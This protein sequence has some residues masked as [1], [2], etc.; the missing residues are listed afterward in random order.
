MEVT[1]HDWTNRRHDDRVATNADQ[2][3]FSAIVHS[4][5]NIEAGTYDDRVAEALD[6]YEVVDPKSVERWAATDITLDNA[7]GEIGSEVRRRQAMLRDAYPFKIN[8]NQLIYKGSQTLVYEFCLAVSTA[9]SL[10]RADHAKLPVAFE[11]LARDVLVCFLG[12]GSEGYRTGWPADEHEKRPTRFRELIQV[13][14]DQ[15]NEWFWRPDHNKPDDPLPKDVKDEGLD[16]VVWKT[17]PDGRGGRLFFLGQCAC[18]NDYATKYNDITPDFKRLHFWINPI[19][20]VLPVR[21]FATPRHI[22]NEPDFEDANK[23][24]GLTLDR[25]RITLLAEENTSR[26]YIIKNCPIPY[27]ELIKIVIPDFEAVEPVPT[28]QP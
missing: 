20:Y 3:E 26:D 22:A 17:I 14:R 7:V 25:G 24:A 28:Q 1:K 27:A 23:Q 13:L 16:F 4:T 21:T 19:S 12:P 5:S 2:A 6:D 18:G 11:R 10:S 15:T 8:E 9:T